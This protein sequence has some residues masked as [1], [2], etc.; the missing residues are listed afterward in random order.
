MKERGFT[1]NDV[2]NIEMQKAI[3]IAQL[4]ADEAARQAL[5]NDEG[6]MLLSDRSAIDPIVYAF[7]TSKSWE[8][9]SQ[10]LIKCKRFQKAL[11]QLRKSVFVLFC[12]VPE[13]MED[14]GVRS[15]D[16]SHRTINAFR[17]IL[18]RLEIPYHEIDASCKPLEDRIN[19]IEEFMRNWNKI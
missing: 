14:D 12:P 3:L 6:R 16:E 13:W 1:R 9:K 5:T 7:L 17:K 11:E 2:G 10:K 8:R 19:R 18:R 4:D 15:I